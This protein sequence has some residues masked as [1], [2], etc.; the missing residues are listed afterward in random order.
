MGGIL[1]LRPRLLLSGTQFWNLLQTAADGSGLLWWW[2]WRWREFLIGVP[3]LMHAFYILGRQSAV[4]SGDGAPLRADPRPW[5]WLSLFFPVGVIAALGR[6]EAE[7]WLVLGQTVV[8][9]SAGLL[10]GAAAL[11]L[12]KA[13]EAWALSPR[14]DRTIDLGRDL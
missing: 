6:P 10:V 3:A 4:P 1:L 12:R 8:V 13:W 14:P 5:L 2:P 7:P 11:V 9:L